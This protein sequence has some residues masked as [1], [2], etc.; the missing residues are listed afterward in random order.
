[1]VTQNMWGELTPGDSHEYGLDFDPFDKNYINE[2]I[3]A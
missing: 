1:M 3:L 2:I